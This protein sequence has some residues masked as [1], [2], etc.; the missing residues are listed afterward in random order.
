MRLQQRLMLH[1]VALPLLLMAAGGVGVGLL[2]R[3]QLVAGLD[4]S[5]RAQAAAESVSLFD[6][7]GGTV[8]FHAIQSPVR[9]A[10]GSPDAAIA[11]YG[12]DGARLARS[13]TAEAAPPQLAPPPDTEPR[14]RSADGQRVLVVRVPSPGGEP[15]ALWLA[16]PLAPVEATM[17]LFTRLGLAGLALVA[18]LL[19]LVQR[20]HARGLARRVEGLARHMRRLQ[21]G[22]LQAEPPPDP[23][24]DVLG[25]LRASVARAT[26]RLRDAREAQERLVAGAAHELR[27]PLAAMRASVD[28]AL[29]RER[30]AAELRET[31]E[32]VREE[33]DRLDR[34]A[35]ALLDLAALRAQE[36]ALVRTDLHDLARESLARFEADASTREVALALEGARDAEATV[37]PDLIRRALDNLLSNALKFAPRG[38]TVRVA[39]ERAGEGWALVVRDEG[40]GVPTAEREHV[41]VPFHRGRQDRPGAGLGLALVRDV[42]ELHGGRVA[43]DETERGATFRL[44]LPATPA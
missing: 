9:A 18:L 32:D 29:R 38:S 24:R 12:P 6:G 1:G 20:R 31:L 43:L 14:L 16:T 41:F 19:L 34:M 44:T 2:L 25:E 26:R 37:V 10:L 17:G 11:A 3:A 8:H 22:D 7:P 23:E 30:D 27:T 28:V 4:N 33:V 5:L 42:A 36:R 39:L 21:A 40:P 13:S 35:T 15:Y